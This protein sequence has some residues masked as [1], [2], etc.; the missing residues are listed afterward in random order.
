MFACHSD[1]G[2]N[3]VASQKL[4]LTTTLSTVKSIDYASQGALTPMTYEARSLTVLQRK[5]ADDTTEAAASSSTRATRSSARVSTGSTKTEEAPAPK[6]KK[7]TKPATE[8]N[9]HR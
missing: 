8:V 9:A 1:K 4:F 2:L 7:Q 5:R 3:Q 6:P